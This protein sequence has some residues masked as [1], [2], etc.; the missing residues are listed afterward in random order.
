MSKITKKDF[1]DHMS[2]LYHE[3]YNDAN[4]YKILLDIIERANDE[5]FLVELLDITTMTKREKLVYR[6][7]LAVQG[8]EFTPRQIDQYI[9]LI[10]YALEHL[11]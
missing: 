6:Y 2:E 9:S 1:F 7:E 10:E 8:K 3:K 11:E 5:K 4:A